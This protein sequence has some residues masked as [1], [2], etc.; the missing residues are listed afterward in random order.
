MD[1]TTSSLVS[2]SSRNKVHHGLH[3]R[4]RPDLTFDHKAAKL[5]YG[6]G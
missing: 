4:S 1:Y 6:T 3:I 2:F 5:S